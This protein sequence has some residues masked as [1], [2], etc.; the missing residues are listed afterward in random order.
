MGVYRTARYVGRLVDGLGG[1]FKC[2]AEDGVNIVLLYS[3]HSHARRHANVG[4]RILAG[5]QVGEDA[6]GWCDGSLSRMFGC[7]ILGRYPRLTTTCN[8]RT[9]AKSLKPKQ[10]RRVRKGQGAQQYSS[11]ADIAANYPAHSTAQA[12]TCVRYHTRRRKDSV[13]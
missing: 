3:P 12:Q 11:S 7:F 1:T 9:R 2:R 8:N 4:V 10:R 5:K 13:L 6:K